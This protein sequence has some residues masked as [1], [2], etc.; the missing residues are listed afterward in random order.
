MPE[1]HEHQRGGVELAIETTYLEVTGLEA[2]IQTN[3]RFGRASETDLFERFYNYMQILYRLTSNEEEMKKN[4]S[5]ECD[6]FRK[7][8]ELPMPKNDPR[9]WILQGIQV[10]DEYDG[11][12]HSCGIIVLPHRVR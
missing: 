5:K 3:I 7:W 6:G 12:L 2:N 10:F 8:L 9:S 4:G 1:T 11:A